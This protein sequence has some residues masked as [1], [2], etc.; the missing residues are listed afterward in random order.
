MSNT[1]PYHDPV[2]VSE[3]IHY[4]APG[5]GR[6]IA[7][8]TLG[9]GGH[10]DAVLSWAGSGGGKIKLLIGIDR[11]PEALEAAAERLSGYGSRAVLKRGCFDDLRVILEE[12]GED[13]V[14]GIL[15]DLGASRH[16]L[17]EGRR[18]M[19][20]SGDG[21]LDMRMDPQN[22]ESAADLLARLDEKSLA[23]IIRDYGEER[24]ARRIARAIVDKRE[25]GTPLKTTGE[26]KRLVEACV[27][28]GK[29]DRIHPA[30]RTFMALRIAVNQ[31]LDRLEAVLEII[32]ECLADEGRAVV[33]S[34][35]SLEDRLVKRSFVREAKG[36][37]CPPRLPR[38][39]CNKSPRL[40]VLT[41]RPVRP[42]GEE[43]AR[44]PAAR[45]AKLRAARRLGADAAQGES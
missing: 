26:L 11:D 29:R 8:A 35:H 33:I 39:V 37:I 6:V 9:G 5:P 25:K 12:E 27:P 3:V 21:P 22:G 10:S 45:S 36:C 15:L 19:S 2:M 1:N 23:G 14:D 17:T 44:N 20:F 41:R 40:E 31:E 38:C 30:T 13:K 32:P 18:G 34:Y 7:D 43:V 24:Y 42:S 28:A 4:L 16:Q